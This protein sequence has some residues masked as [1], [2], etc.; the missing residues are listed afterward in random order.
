M[1]ALF[2]IYDL[3]A[4]GGI[5]R[6]KFIRATARTVLV[7]HGVL[8]DRVLAPFPRALAVT[9]PQLEG[10]ALLQPLVIPA[11]LALA[12]FGTHNLLV[13]SQSF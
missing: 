4:V 2:T 8:V 5:T 11:V 7:G 6:F 10:I 12:G 1:I 3:L 13:I 9:L